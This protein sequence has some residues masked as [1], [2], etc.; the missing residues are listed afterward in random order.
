MKNKIREA[1]NALF[2]GLLPPPVYYIV[3]ISHHPVFLKTCFLVAVLHYTVELNLNL[4]E[5]SFPIGHQDWYIFVLQ[6]NVFWAVIYILIY[7]S[8]IAPLGFFLFVC[9]VR[10]FVCLKRHLI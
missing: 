1:L 9:F 8:L 3:I 7:R 4:L 5:H 2:C 6:I 10:L